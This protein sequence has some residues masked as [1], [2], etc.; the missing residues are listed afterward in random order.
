MLLN[1][2]IPAF[3]NFL[4]DVNLPAVTDCKKMRIKAG[5][6]DLSAVLTAQ[7]G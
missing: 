4:Q 1:A 5:G 2:I 7:A 6:F 3:I